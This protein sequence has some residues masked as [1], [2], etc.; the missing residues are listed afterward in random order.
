MPESIKDPIG[1]VLGMYNAYPTGA[2]ALLH[3]SAFT[4]VCVCECTRVCVCVCVCVC[5]FKGRKLH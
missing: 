5:V 4:G 1:V 3:Y 2:G